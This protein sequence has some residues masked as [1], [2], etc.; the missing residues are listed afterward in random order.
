MERHGVLA[1]LTE[2]DGKVHSQMDI[3]DQF[4]LRAAVDFIRKKED[5]KV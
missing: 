2:A 3:Y 5:L 4:L 1:V